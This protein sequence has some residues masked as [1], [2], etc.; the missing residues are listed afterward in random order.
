MA[1]SIGASPASGKELTQKERVAAL[2]AEARAAY[3]DAA[4]ARDHSRAEAGVRTAREH[5]AEA[6]EAGGAQ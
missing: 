4:P 1:Q 3:A 5:C 2:H 6:L